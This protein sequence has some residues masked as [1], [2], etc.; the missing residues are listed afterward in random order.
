MNA[1]RFALLSF[2]M[3]CIML[4]A[5]V[6]FHMGSQSAEAQV[7]DPTGDI[8]AVSNASALDRLGQHWKFDTASAPGASN[9]CWVRRGDLDPPIPVTA[10]RMWQGGVVVAT[11]GDVW[12]TAADPE[13]GTTWHNC[14]PWPGGGPVST[15]ESTLGN[16]K[17]IFK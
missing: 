13:L 16:V 15:N 14:G 11:N 7:V 10:I 2:G 9:K 6:G 4:S 8:I 3:L 12:V 5:L 17:S 1:K